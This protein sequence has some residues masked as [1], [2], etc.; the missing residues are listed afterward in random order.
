MPNSVIASDDLE[1]SIKIK[2]QEKQ[3]KK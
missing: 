1:E 3:F 2:C